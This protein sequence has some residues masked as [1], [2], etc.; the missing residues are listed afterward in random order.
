MVYWL[1]RRYVSE[2]AALLAACCFLADS[3]V[4]NF[5]YN[6]S[7]DVFGTVL[8]LGG[9]LCVWRKEAGVLRLVAGGCSLACR[10]G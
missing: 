3:P 7:P 2:W 1:T 4:R 5:M 10:Y 6:V 9:V 8:V